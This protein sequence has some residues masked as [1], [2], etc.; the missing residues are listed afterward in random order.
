AASGLRH[1]GGLPDLLRPDAGGR[2]GLARRPARA[3][4]QALTHAEGGG[5]RAARRRARHRAMRIA[6]CFAASVDQVREAHFMGEEAVGRRIR[7]RT[8]CT[9]GPFF[10]LSANTRARSGSLANPSNLLMRSSRLSQ[11]RR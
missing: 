5:A 10:S 11:A 2:E 8:C 1:R 9:I 6:W 7:L 4:A 3:S